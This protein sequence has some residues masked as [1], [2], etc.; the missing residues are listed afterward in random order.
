MLI[1]NIIRSLLWSIRFSC[2]LV[3]YLQF[4]IIFWTINYFNNLYK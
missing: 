1:L 3:I 2:N 4:I